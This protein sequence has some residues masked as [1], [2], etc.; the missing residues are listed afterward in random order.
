MDDRL[1]HR[2]TPERARGGGDDRVRPDDPLLAKQVLSQLSYAPTARRLRRRAK[3]DATHVLLCGTKP[4][5]KRLQRAASAEASKWLRSR[6]PSGHLP[7]RVAARS[8]R[9]GGPGRI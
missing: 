1:H 3:H 4:G 6:C 5:D 2:A 8:A 9:L 7:L